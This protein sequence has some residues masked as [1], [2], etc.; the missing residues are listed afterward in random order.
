MKN[1]TKSAHRTL[2]MLIAVAALAVAGLGISL[3]AT[4]ASGQVGNGTVDWNGWTLN[5]GVQSGFDGLRLTDVKYEGVQM[6]GQMSLPVMNVYYQNNACGPY[7]DRLGGTVIGLYTNEF[8]QNGERWLEIAV[9]DHIGAYVIYQ[10]FYLSENGVLDAHMFSKGLQCN[11][12]HEHLPFWRFDF[13]VD[14]SA[15]DQI[16]RRTNGSLQAETQEFN[17]SATAADDHEWY[18]RDTVSGKTVRLNFD[19]GTYN[20]AG[21]VVPERAY[22]QNNVFGRQY[23]QSESI[24]RGGPTRSLGFNEGE[25]I[26]DVVLWY[27][28]YMPHSAAEGPNLWHSTGVRM[29]F[30][31]DPTGATPPPTTT[32]T[33]TTTTT[34][35]SPPSP[36]GNLLSNGS[37]E[38][39]SLGGASSFGFVRLADWDTSRA[40]DTAE[41]WRSGFS[42]VTA[43]DG[44]QLIELNGSSPERIT[45]TVSVTP[46]ETYT[47]SIDHQGRVD[48][49]SIQVDINGTSQ[50]V[51]VAAP[52]SWTTQTGTYTPTGDT[53]EISFR[54][55]DF[56]TVGNLLDNAIVQ[57][58]VVPPPTTTTTAPPTTTTAPPTT[59]TTATTTTTTTPTPTPTQCSTALS[60]EAEDG[61]LS[62]LMQVVG[63]STASG[64]Q[65]IHVPP[66]EANVWTLG[67]PSQASYCFNL[68]QAGTYRIEGDVQGLDALADSMFVTVDGQPSGGY[69]WDSPGFG[70]YR[71]D[72][73]SDR[74]GDDPV[75]VD[76]TAGEHTVT[77]HLRETGTRLDSL[78]LVRVGGPTTPPTPVDCSTN[79]SREAENGALSGQMQTVADGAASGGQYVVVPQGSGY[80]WSLGSSSQASY[81][82]TITEASNYRIEGVAYGSAPLSD[83]FFVTVDGQPTEGYL[84]DTP[85]NETYRND[86]VSDRNGADP[87]VVNLSAG[88]HTI[89]FHHREDGTRLDTVKLVAVN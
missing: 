56:G 16:L 46:G 68:A 58:G 60:R 70:S 24:W 38:R 30:V 84:W 88:E 83:S 55:R 54:A 19:D 37:F 76:L 21:D 64:Q 61:E 51:Y 65:Y 4:P 78:R 89:T 6:A 18:V 63:D 11:I 35:P 23:K 49:D 29:E 52:G 47:W 81:C 25:A 79:L 44:G 53:L 77:F 27:S 15:N 43:S 62:G 9:E 22:V 3:A 8:T 5:Y 20:Q 66:T 32:A 75:T 72:N 67:S 71:A 73:V 50:G 2:K 40:G 41:V 17:Q 86:Y 7:A 82:F 10:S 14:G 48:A 1:V 26:N 87:V 36:S 42:G 57:L 12:Y 39:E 74:T 31:D 59:P 80:S 69:L 13:D 33:T 28:G 34:T 85:A 45:Q